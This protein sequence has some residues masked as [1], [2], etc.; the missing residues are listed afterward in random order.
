MLTA[1]VD[2]CIRGPAPAPS[3]DTFWS[4]PWLRQAAK[5]SSTSNA[6]LIAAKTKAKAKAD[7]DRE[8]AKSD[9]GSTVEMLQSLVM[10]GTDLHNECDWV[11]RNFAARQ[12]AR[13]DEIEAIGQAKAI[14]SGEK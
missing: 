10:T 13:L 7:E 1:S 3:I 2:S 11:L 14:L 8:Q 12:K 4:A 6:G 5:R 9:L